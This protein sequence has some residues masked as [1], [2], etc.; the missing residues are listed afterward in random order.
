MLLHICTGK[1]NCNF[2]CP[3]PFAGIYGFLVKKK[4]YLSSLLTFLTLAESA[5]ERENFQN[6]HIA[7]HITN[8][9]QKCFGLFRNYFYFTDMVFTHLL[10]NCI[11]KGF[12]FCQGW[13]KS[14]QHPD[15]L[16]SARLWGKQRSTSLPDRH[17]LH[18]SCLCFYEVCYIKQDMSE[19]PIQ[20]HNSLYANVYEHDWIGMALLY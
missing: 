6:L 16:L 17:K 2:V 5:L 11:I 15:V 7:F 13:L 10:L 12:L 8:Q 1:K 9:S 18:L 20:V 19:A 4:N 3:I 14:R